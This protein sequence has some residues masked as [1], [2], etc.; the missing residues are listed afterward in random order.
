M[1]IDKAMNLINSNEEN[2]IDDLQR[3]ISIPSVS[4]DVDG[5]KKALKTLL[6]LAKSMGFKTNLLAKD[7]V[8][9]IELNCSKTK[10]ETIGILTHIDVVDP[11]N[12]KKW[13]TD[14][15]KSVR[16]DG[17]IFG[18]GA[19][20]DKGPLI[21]CLYA[22]YA[23]KN[24]ETEFNKNIKMVIGTCEEDTWDDMDEY[25]KNYPLPDFGF[26]P[27]GE[28]PITNI[29]KGY[30]DVRLSF[31][32]SEKADGDFEVISLDGGSAV[33][34]VPDLATATIFG[35]KVEF[36]RIYK[37]FLNKSTAK[38]WL[39]YEIKDEKIIVTA[40]G[41]SC[42]SS[43]PSQGKNAITRLMKF[44]YMLPLK[45]KGIAN[46]AEFVKLSF[47]KEIYGKT[48]GFPQ[49]SKW[50]NGEFVD[51]TTSLPVLLKLDGT[52]LDLCVNLRISPGISKKKIEQIFNSWQKKY[53]YTYHFENY[54]DPLFVKRDE[55]FLKILSQSYSSVE[56]TR[57]LF[58]LAYGTSYAKAIEHHVAFGPL[59]YNE[60][61]T[62]H[63]AN[64]RIA[65]ESL[66]K[67]TSIY[68]KALYEMAI[69]KTSLRKK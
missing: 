38:N 10:A 15:F 4:N 26:T 19:I 8:G 52:K 47:G 3:L 36:I 6:Y 67:A 48:L 28:F 40:T 25:T 24:S 51:K 64:E 42:H 2:M 7:R 13:N 53:K 1:S 68:T 27:D 44:L 11:G 49:K 34:T 66:M 61:D 17:F 37:K 18:R 60:V 12:I 32:N 63:Q 5:C 9:T 29:E 59:F 69:C 65:V 45:N 41:L 23:L 31:E 30:A 46:L 22:M 14:P 62:S 56:K 55:P 57:R 54:Q 39:S 16:K 35:N 43:M 20:D 21:S 58:S 33:N 50:L